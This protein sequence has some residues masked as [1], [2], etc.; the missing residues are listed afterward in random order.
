MPVMKIDGYPVEFT[1]EP[2]IL[3][4]IRKAGINLPT[5][6]YHSELSIY[7]ACR[8][9]T[10]EDDKGRM[11]ASCSERPRDGLSIKTSTPRLVRYRRMLIELMLA[12][13]HRDCTTCVKSGDC[14]LQNLAHRLGVSEVRW[15]Y[16]QRTH[17]RDFS[18]PS[19][20]RDPDKC[21]LCGDCVRVCEGIQG[22][23]AIDFAMRGT[24][25]MVI[26]AFNKEIA[27]TDCVNC[28]QCR[29]V[30]PTGAISINTNIRPVWEA[31]A[32]PDV[33]VFAQVAPAV[34]VAAGQAFGGAKGENVMGKIVAALHKLGFDEVYDTTFGADMT[35]LEESKEFLELFKKGGP[36]P[37][38]TSCC[39][40]WVSFCEK[41][42]PE[43]VPH[44]ST[45]YSPIQ[46]L[47]SI[48][49]EYYAD[50][51][52]NEGKKILS[53]GIMPCT[54]KKA[55][56]LREDLKR[57]GKQNIDYV[58]TTEEMITMIKRAGIQFDKLEGEAADMPF[59]MGSGGGVIFGNSGGVME[60]ALRTLCEGPDRPA[61][62]ELR[63]SGVRGPSPL[64]EFT[65]NYKGNEIKA[66]V[67]SG[68]AEADALLRRIKN[69]ESFYHFVEVMACRRGCIM[70]GGQPAHAGIRTKEARKHGLYESDVNT[71]IK[72]SNENPTALAIY[73]TLIKGREHELLH[74]HR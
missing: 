50:P 7:G 23:N 35:I 33:K 72:K 28:G 52:N 31:L 58:L 54:A 73:D 14:E 59:G 71:Q 10:V 29:V 27:K 41:R 55:E 37:L 53:V 70:G 34:R 20:V 42:W 57:D 38:F 8:L 43:F 69:G 74:S 67:V 40:A 62:E 1:D 47:G 5:L 61:I 49:R 24:D 17:K 18:S 21:I 36:F 26:P 63:Q 51:K 6:C 3:S 44:I 45:S 46:M 65:F 48:A 68:L 15:G 4:V 2:N 64:R 22:I 11:F 56:I 66:A 30:C 16:K 12:S 60:A 25:A 32:D 9:C 19:I 39:P 13:H